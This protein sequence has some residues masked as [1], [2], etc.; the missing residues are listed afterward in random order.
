[1]VKDFH[2]HS[3]HDHIEP[4][5]MATQRADYAFVGIKISGADPLKSIEEIKQLWESV[6]PEKIFEYH[7]L[8]DQIAAF[9]KKEDLLNKLTGSATVIA[10]VIS[11]VGLLGLISLLTIQRT[12]EIGI[13]KVI[14]ASVINILLLL[15]NDFIKLTGLALILATAVGWL[16]MSNWLQGFAYR[17][18]I[19]WWIFLL[20]GVCNLVLALATICYHAVRVALM[21]PV[22]SLRAE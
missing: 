1:V 5:L 3:L 9:Y 7:F 16:A 18:T 17:I 4:V 8:D 11:C 22:K 10:I 2:L 20:A 12:K 14:G 6:Y 13:R 15:S 21:N 19:P